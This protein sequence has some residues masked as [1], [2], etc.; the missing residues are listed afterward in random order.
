MLTAGVLGTVLGDDTS[1]AVGESGA[2]IGLGL[3]LAAVI[4]TTGA[5]ARTVAAYWGIVAVARTAGSSIGD[6]L[7]ENDILAIGLPLSTLITGAT[8]VAALLFWR[9][10]TGREAAV[11]GLQS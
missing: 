5:R 7:A 4:F 6:W 11:G 9:F 1:H 2:S 3:A 10:E 8:F